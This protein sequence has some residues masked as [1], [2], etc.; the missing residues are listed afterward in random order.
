MAVNYLMCIAQEEPEGIRL[1]GLSLKMHLCLSFAGKFAFTG[2][3]VWSSLVDDQHQKCSQ[4][5]TRLL[6]GTKMVILHC[7]ILL[8]QALFVTVYSSVYH[9]LVHTLYQYITIHNDHEDFVCLQS[10]VHFALT[11]TGY[12]QLEILC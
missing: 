9:S 12:F 2:L 6:H 10:C 3:S 11:H 7:I 1:S 5:K 8:L 4:G